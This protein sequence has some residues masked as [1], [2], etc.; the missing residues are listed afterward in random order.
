MK[1]NLPKEK[2]EEIDSGFDIPQKKA[3]EDRGPI[4][5]SQPTVLFDQETVLVLNWKALSN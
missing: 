3:E 1:S 5:Y 4:P 2:P